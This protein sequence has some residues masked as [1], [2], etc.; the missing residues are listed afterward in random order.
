MDSEGER[1]VI[2]GLVSFVETFA[3]ELIATNKYTASKVNDAAT[4]TKSYF[5][6]LINALTDKS[7][8]GYTDLTFDSNSFTYVNA[9]GESVTETAKYRHIQDDTEN[10]AKEYG[11][12]ET[13]WTEQSGVAI[14][15]NVDWGSND[16]AI[17]LDK[18]KV[19]QKFIEFFNTLL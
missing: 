6:A 4:A 19:A 5:E 1:T 10:G 16:F 11:K 9:K 18:Q 17:Y 3:G 2:A 7:G 12:E 15:E 13:K 14:L 8:G